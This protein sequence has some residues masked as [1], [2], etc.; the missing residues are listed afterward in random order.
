APAPANNGSEMDF[1][2]NLLS[3]PHMMRLDLAFDQVKMAHQSIFQSVMLTGLF[4]QDKWQ[5]LDLTAK[6]DA[7]SRLEFHLSPAENYRELTFTSNN[8]GLILS[9][10]G[11]SETLM[12]GAIDV[13][14]RL[15][16]DQWEGNYHINMKNYR[17]V[18]APVMARILAVV[19]I[20]SIPDLMAGEGI[21]FQDLNVELRRVEKGWEIKSLLARGS[22]LGL[23]LKGLILGRE[24]ELNLDGTVV[25]LYGISKIVGA[26]PVVGQ[27]LT[28]GAAGGIFAWSF[29]I[30]GK[31]EQP[32]VGVNPLSALTPGFLRSLI[33]KMQPQQK[34]DETAP[35][36]PPPDIPNSAN[37]LK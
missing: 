4:K 25:P 10:L 7:N 35:N 2:A 31:P 27:I 14:A 3:F 29:Y 16:N 26:I 9:S 18:K 33:E 21:V 30:H 5:K 12:G 24:H 8:A 37:G 23:A 28:G 22:S 34:F 20:T 17:L 19:S 6:L 36:A 32:E 15:E 11:I 1:D 13:K